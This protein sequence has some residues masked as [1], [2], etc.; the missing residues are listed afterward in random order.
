MLPIGSHCLDPHNEVSRSLPDQLN[1][2]CDLSMLT[3][4]PKFM[5]CKYSNIYSEVKVWRI[6][7]MTKFNLCPL[8]PSTYN[9]YNYYDMNGIPQRATRLCYII[10]LT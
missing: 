8:S 2:D 5:Y 9:S 7:I 1:F 6:I 4:V 10:M 3:F